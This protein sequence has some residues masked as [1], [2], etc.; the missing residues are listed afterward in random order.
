MLTVCPDVQAAAAAVNAEHASQVN[1]DSFGSG[2]RS[3]HLAVCVQLNRLPHAV[4]QR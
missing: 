2:S 3:R 1:V 4:M